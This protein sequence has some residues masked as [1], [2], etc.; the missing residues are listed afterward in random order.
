MVDIHTY[1]NIVQNNFTAKK[2]KENIHRRLH[3]NMVKST[4]D[5]QDICVRRA[6]FFI[7]EKMSFDYIFHHQKPVT[8]TFLDNFI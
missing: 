2:K 7:Q 1:I 4:T 5:W 6:F 3:F 8:S